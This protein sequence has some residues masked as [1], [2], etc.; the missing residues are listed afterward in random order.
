[1]LR[2]VNLDAW[3]ALFANADGRGLPLSS[4]I[5]G[6]PPGQPVEQYARLAHLRR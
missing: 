5:D 4:V 1:V 2:E 6:D 3:L